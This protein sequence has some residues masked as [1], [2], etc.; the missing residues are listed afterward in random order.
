MNKE[1]LRQIDR[2][3]A[4]VLFNKVYGP[5]EYEAWCQ[6]GGLGNE[7]FVDN[8]GVVYRQDRVWRPTE[9]LN[10]WYRAEATMTSTYWNGKQRQAYIDSLFVLL[11]PNMEKKTVWTQP[12]ARRVAFEL[13]TAPLPLRCLAFLSAANK[14]IEDA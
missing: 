2:A 14:E 10:D 6:A 7:A 4:T 8:E 12:L 5:D 11:Y 3:M 13:A 9:Y 1:R